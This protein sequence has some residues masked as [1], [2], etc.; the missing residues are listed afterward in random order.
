MRDPSME[1]Y[2]SPKADP[3]VGFPW[4]IIHKYWN[5]A[6]KRDACNYGLRHGRYLIITCSK[7]SVR[8]THYS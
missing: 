6:E 5:D 7:I 4:G 8:V 1:T 3:V 2:R